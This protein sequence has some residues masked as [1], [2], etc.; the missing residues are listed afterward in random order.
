[1]LALLYL[2][3]ARTFVPPPLRRDEAGQAMAEYALVILGAAAIAVAVGSWVSRSDVVG[4]LL[5]AVFNRL[6]GKANQG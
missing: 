5:D 1:M 2:L 4:G 6:L 3:H